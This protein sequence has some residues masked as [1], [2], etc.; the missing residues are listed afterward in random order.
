VRV[1]L[2][3][4]GDR[5]LPLQPRAASR[6][7]AA[8]LRRRGV[9][10]ALSRRAERVERGVVIADGRVFE[11]DLAVVATGLR[12]PR[13]LGALGLPL[14]EEGGLRVDATLQ[15]IADER[16]FGAGD[17]IRLEG[18]RLPK[19]GVYGVRQAPVLL[20]N[21]WALLQG[22]PLQRF[23]PQQRCLMILNLGDGR[24][25]A[26]WGPLHWQGRLSLRLKDAID[27]RFLAK[28][29]AAGA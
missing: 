1:T 25:L 9:D 20:H 21:L 4:G 26:L 15:S 17:C 29:R 2:V 12:P 14:D 13:W 5:L 24:G 3:T 19:L 8:L 10:L 27:R 6:R 11:A 28:Y 22:R 7:L 16:I 23:R 18:R